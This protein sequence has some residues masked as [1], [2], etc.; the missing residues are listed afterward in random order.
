[1]F[2]GIT[3]GISIKFAKK[4][5]N[6]NENIM[7]ERK[8]KYYERKCCWIFL[9]CKI[10]LF[11]SSLCKKLKFLEI[12]L[13]KFELGEYKHWDKKINKKVS[14]RWSRY[15]KNWLIILKTFRNSCVEINLQKCE[16][17]N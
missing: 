12:I 1:M 13:N 9:F 8:W 10:L 5:L 4:I 11:A 15:S 2:K 6:E 7:K 16:W 14:L 17:C 3:E